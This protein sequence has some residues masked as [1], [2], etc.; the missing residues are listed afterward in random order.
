MKESAFAVTG[1]LPV[2]LVGPTGSG[3]SDL[4]LQLARL[5][6][7]EIVNAD[8]FQL[9]HGLPVLTASP[10]PAD[11]AA[12]PHH[13]YGVLSPEETCHAG[14][15]LELA[16]PVLA[17]IAARGVLPIVVGG[18]GLYIKALTH[19]LSEAPA[20]QPGLRARLDQLSQ[21]ELSRILIHLDPAATATI[22]GGN[23]RYIQR[24]VE[25]SLLAGRPASSLR[26]SWTADPPGLRGLF[27]IRSRQQLHERIHR[28]TEA[29]LQQG[30]IDEVTA[31][32]KWSATSEK[33]IGAREI[34][35]L[36]RGEIDQAACIAAIDLAT[37][38]YAKRQMTWFR[39]EHWLLP[40]TE[41]TGALEI[42]SFARLL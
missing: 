33:A 34:Q 20:S 8:A 4:A 22:A 35:Q 25:I 38:R 15:Y 18:S 2:Y 26:E 6:G 11:C 41:E 42:A 9:Y 19:G 5:T 12:V 27:L 3:K 13:L 1:P 30:A 31:V 21:G 28:R 36:T 14:R 32:R 17:D 37:R 40:V 16:R 29:M 39:R 23:R 24:A 10:S 7:G